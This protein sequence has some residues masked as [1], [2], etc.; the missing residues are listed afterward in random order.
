MPRK[1]PEATDRDVSGPVVEQRKDIALYDPT[2][3][4]AIRAKRQRDDDR[5]RDAVTAREQLLAQAAAPGEHPDVVV[6][7]KQT[8]RAAIAEQERIDAGKRAAERQQPQ[9]PAPPPPTEGTLPEEA[10]AVHPFV[11]D[12]RG[13]APHPATVPAGPMDSDVRYETDDIAP[14]GTPLIQ[15]QPQGFVEPSPHLDG[16]SDREY[17]ADGR[18]WQHSP[19]EQAGEMGDDG[20]VPVVNSHS[21][22]GARLDELKLQR[23][24]VYVPNAATLDPVSGKGQA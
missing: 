24:V 4:E 3:P 23:P 7:T 22:E 1:R 9:P 21:E 6:A 12:A 10:H 11:P 8:E 15:G 5:N 14:D 16:E 19:A 13:S 18:R 17:P 20:L 2:T